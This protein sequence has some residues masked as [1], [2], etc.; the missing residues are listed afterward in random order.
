RINSVNPLDRA[1]HADLEARISRMARRFQGFGRPLVF[2]QSPLA[3]PELDNILDARG[4]RRFDETRVMTMDLTQAELTGAVDQLPLRDIGR[5]ID[6]NAIMEGFPAS[7]KPGLSEIINNVQGEVGLFLSEDDNGNPLAAAMAVRFG[8]LVGLFEIVSNPDLRG[9]GFGRRIVRN[10][11]LWGR[12]HG[13][14]Q[15]WLQVVA[16]NEVANSLYESEGFNEVYRYAYR[17]A[18]DNFHG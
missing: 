11:L 3:P 4:W 7:V 1:D 12:E 9:L 14:R 16:N 10:A 13:A 5:W 17:Q 15:A 6:Q 2:R 18:P 8:D